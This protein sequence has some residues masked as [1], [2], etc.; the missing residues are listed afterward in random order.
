VSSRETLEFIVSY[1]VDYPDDIQVTESD[2]GR[3]VVYE[4]AVH[5]DD[6]GKVIGRNGRIAKA[7]R[8]VVRAAAARDDQ[9]AVVEI[10]G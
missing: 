5:P 7:L 9:N 1:L 8:T 3:T 6:V 2:S 4:L 10:L